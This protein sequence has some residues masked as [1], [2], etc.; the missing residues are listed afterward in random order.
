MN[1]TKALFWA[2]AGAGVFY[3]AKALL[4]ESRKIDFAN[5]VVVI[6]GGSRGLG[7]VMARELA[8]E[9]AKI[10]IC[11][12]D[13]SEL[14]TAKFDLL[15][16][17]ANVFTHRCDVTSK[18]EIQ[19]FI[20]AVK[21]HFGQIDVLINNAGVIQVTPYEHATEADFDEALKTH[22]WAC[23]H[24]I[25]EVLPEMRERRFGRIVNISSIGGKIAIPHLVPYATSKF[26]L[27][28][29]SEGL[30]SE[31]V[32]DNIFVTTVCPGLIRTGSPRNAFFKGQHEKEYAWFKIGDS[33]P[34]VSVS[35]EQCAR[36]II[37][38]ARYG[39]PE[40]IVSLAAQTMAKF[41]GLFPGVTAEI[42][43]LVNQFLPAPGGIGEQRVKGKDSETA[44][45][46]NVLT[47]LTDQAAGD[48]NQFAH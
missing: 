14:E 30:R 2:A 27:V 48:N 21:T 44:A 11:A 42:N 39:K 36:E 9:N 8:K 10:A 25:S 38:A 15:E 20:R 35:A 40:H 5:K 22:F 45:S 37:A 34:L 6:T 12:R 46:E 3:A 1:G 19:E 29:Y 17:G 26:A 4:A 31:L 32:K 47:A 28:G 23:F 24:T 43:A 18:A 13:E 41:H 16:Q 33:L 7:L